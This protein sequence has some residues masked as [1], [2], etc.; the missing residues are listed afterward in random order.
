MVEKQL[1][2]IDLGV[3]MSK[4]L[5]MIQECVLM[6]KKATSILGCFRQS[7]ASRSREVILL[8]WS[9]LVRHVWSAVSSAGLPSTR[10]TWTYRNESGKE[11]QR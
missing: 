4:K 7:A 10:E 3:L 5:T 8:L 2:R 1:G 9:A 6:A 11:P